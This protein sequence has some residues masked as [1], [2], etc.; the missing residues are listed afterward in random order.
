MAYIV[1]MSVLAHSQ[2]HTLPIADYR[3]TYGLFFPAP[4][5]AD[6]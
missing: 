4:R 6:G 2:Q 3:L 5:I 1:I